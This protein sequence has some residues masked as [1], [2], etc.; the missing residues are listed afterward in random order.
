MRRG[1]NLTILVTRGLGTIAVQETAVICDQAEPRVSL[2]QQCGR[3][4]NR[5]AFAKFLPASG[6]AFAQARGAQYLGI[7]IPYDALLVLRTAQTRPPPAFR[8]AQAR[9]SASERVINSRVLMTTSS[10]AL[11]CHTSNWIRVV[12]HA[13]GYDLTGPSR[14]LRHPFTTSFHPTDSITTRVYEHDA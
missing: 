3:G 8:R 13:M 10:C 1:T 7:K 12:A 14:P 2:A 4:E 11:L 9:R 6:P 5:S